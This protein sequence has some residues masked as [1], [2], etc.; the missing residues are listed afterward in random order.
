MLQALR[1]WAESEVTTREH[2]RRVM[3]VYEGF[4]TVL[5]WIRAGQEKEREL[6]EVKRRLEETRVQLERSK[7]EFGDFARN[8]WKIAGWFL[9]FLVL[10]LILCLVWAIIFH[11]SDLRDVYSYVTGAENSINRT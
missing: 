7:R 5:M 10:A 1:H 6:D 3:V 4:L 11:T 8:T 2:L 9:L